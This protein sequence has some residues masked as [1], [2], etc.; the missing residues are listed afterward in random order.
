MKPIICYKKQSLLLALLIFTVYTAYAGKPDHFKV[1]GF[2]L[3]LRIQVMKMPALKQFALNLSK[4][5]INTLVMEW[6]ANYPYQEE[7][8]IAGRYAYSR[9]EI[10]DFIRYCK[11]LSIDV[12]PLQQSF[13][14]VEYI[15]RHYKYAALRED[16]KDFSQVCPSEPELNKALFTTLYKDLIATHPSSFIHIGGDE[17]YLLGHCEKCKKKA[18]ELGLSRLYFDHIKL[19]CDI[20][21]S[22]GKRPVVWADIALKYP[23]FINLLPKQTV[24][25][26]W[27]YGWPMN[28]FGDHQKLVSSGYEIWGAPAIR[29]DPDNY[30]LT[31]WQ[32]HFNNIRS[33]IPECRSLGYSGIIMTSWSTSGAYS[34]VFDSEND[35]LELYAIRHVYPL[36]GFNMLIAAYE[37]ALNSPDPLDIDN[38]IDDYCS[39]EYGLDRKEAKLLKEALFT[40]PYKINKG[41]VRS[42]APMTLDQLLDS[43]RYAS[44]ILHSV[45]PAKNGAA[46]SHYRLMADIRVYY[47]EYM[48][49]EAWLNSTAFKEKDIPGAIARLGKLKSL[50]LQLNQAFR[51]VNQSLLYPSALEEENILRNQKV[52]QLYE[53]LARIR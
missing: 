3:D 44:R 28:N 12:I 25:V 45:H 49:I 10:V 47:L 14:H 32:K 6:E 46:F 41:K 29:S 35:L 42:D 17:T 1:R 20:V 51:Q 24:F 52:H 4:K 37:K 9:A 30:F 19:L 36:S 38:F 53:R 40:A 2:H 22:L 7:P 13:G 31:C 43:A 23:D 48:S 26:D 27:N 39:S 18:A 21:V 34:S 15:L 5:G 50:E 11:T 8:L 16:D 33:F